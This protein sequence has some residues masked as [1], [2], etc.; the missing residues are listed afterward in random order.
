M[1]ARG[2]SPEI[3]ECQKKT[4]LIYGV[5]KSWAPDHDHTCPGPCEQSA[6]VSSDAACS[7]DPIRGQFSILRHVMVTVEFSSKPPDIVDALQMWT[8]RVYLN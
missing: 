8:C 2:R 6:E 3:A 5:N 7:H 4:I 1:P